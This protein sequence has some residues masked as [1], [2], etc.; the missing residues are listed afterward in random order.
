[1]SQ[2]PPSPPHP[3]PSSG[4]KSA[5][6]KSDSLS[7]D[8]IG[9]GPTHFA[10]PPTNLDRTNITRP[11]DYS[12]SKLEPE[13]GNPKGD[14]FYDVIAFFII[15]E[16]HKRVALAIHDKAIW[17]PFIASPANKTWNEATIDGVSIIFSKE[18]SELDARLTR[19]APVEAITCLQILRVQL[20]ISQKFVS[21]VIQKIKLG[22]NTATFKVSSRW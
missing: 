6:D 5:S 13:G 3:T 8:S 18:Y 16:R 17:L 11:L 15:C 20:P 14:C 1:M 22:P 12:S 19:D 2:K 4:I 9:L 7:L 10:A 21:R